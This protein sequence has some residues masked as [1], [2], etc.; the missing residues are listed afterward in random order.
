M[1]K[2]AAY[3]QMERSTMDNG[4]TTECMGKVKTQ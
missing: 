1:A 4:K 3:S 2:E